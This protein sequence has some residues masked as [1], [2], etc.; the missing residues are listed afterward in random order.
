MIQTRPGGYVLR[1]APDQVDAAVFERLLELRQQATVER[2]DA[3]LALGA[4]S[5]LIGELEALFAAN[6]LQ[7]KLRE[8][9]MR[10]LYRAGRQ[11]EALEIYRQTSDLLR[12]ELGLEP[13]RALQ[14]LE[15]SI[16]SDLKAGSSES[17]KLVV[18]H[19]VALVSEREE[20]RRG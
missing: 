20:V 8:R 14:E 17:I 11:S 13:S 2:I 4:H 5:E 12:R 6:P 3:D 7:E 9:L 10:A 16:A 1:A 15:R 19:E 18:Q